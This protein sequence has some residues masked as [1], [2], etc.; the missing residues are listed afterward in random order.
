MSRTSTENF[1]GSETILLDTLRW[2][3]VI[4]TFVQTHRMYS[5][6]VN[7]DVDFG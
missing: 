2:L 4:I 6:R 1:Y 5:P 7:P 3:D